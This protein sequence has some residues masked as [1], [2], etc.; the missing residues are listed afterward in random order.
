MHNKVK[1]AEKLIRKDLL[2]QKNLKIID[3]TITQKL[4]MKHTHYVKQSN[5]KINKKRIRKPIELTFDMMDKIN[6]SKTLSTNH[7][8]PNE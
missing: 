5:P 3:S 6:T 7:N 8:E 2:Y 4:G 1:D